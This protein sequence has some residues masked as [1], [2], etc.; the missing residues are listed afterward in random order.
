MTSTSENEVMPSPEIA[1]TPETA[2]DVNEDLR[3]RVFS[4]PS[5]NPASAEVPV[6]TVEQA[7]TNGDGDS[8]ISTS[9]VSGGTEKIADTVKDIATKD[10]ATADAEAMKE[11][12]K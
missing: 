10:N 11:S 2:E 6:T 12:E 5:P 4:K 9:T 1:P 3:A 7:V 8:V